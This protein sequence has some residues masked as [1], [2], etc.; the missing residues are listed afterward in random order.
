MEEYDNPT[1]G[2]LLCTNKDETFVEY[3]LEGLDEKLF[4]SKYLLHI[5][6][7]EK[8]E[9]FIKKEITNY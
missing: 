2:I 4:V 8:F 7:K 9:D 1:I 3:A 5:P 6:A